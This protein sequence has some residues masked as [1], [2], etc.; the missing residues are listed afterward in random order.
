MGKIA[1][2]K[3]FHVKDAI[4]HRQPQPN[5]QYNASD[6]KDK[7]RAH[8][9]SN[10]RGNMDLDTCSWYHFSF[11]NDTDKIVDEGEDNEGG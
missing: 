1:R 4:D 8:K 5:P 6:C 3:D 11:V 2:R 7:P 10:V 9:A